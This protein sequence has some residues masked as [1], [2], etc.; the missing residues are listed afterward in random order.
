MNWKSILG[1][2]LIIA[3][4]VL[5]VMVIIKSGKRGNPDSLEKARKAKLDKALARSIETID[6][7][8]DAIDKLLDEINE[9]KKDDEPPKDT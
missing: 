4:G 7:S 6:E 5:I 1:W 9:K 3:S 8:Q 2:V